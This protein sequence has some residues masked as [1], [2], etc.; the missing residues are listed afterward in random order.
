MRHLIIAFLLAL[1]F[2]PDVRSANIATADP[3][4]SMVSGLLVAPGLAGYPSP[5]HPTDLRCEYLKDPLGIER[6]NPRL[7]WILET[8]DSALRNQRQIAYQIL[9]SHDRKILNAGEGELWNSGRVNSGQSI[10]VRYAGKP[11]GSGDDCFWKVR[12][13]DEQGK[14]SAWSEPKHWHMG[15][16]KASDW[17]AK[18]IGW[19]E[20]ANSLSENS[21]KIERAREGR[22][23]SPQPSPPTLKA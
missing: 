1:A 7:S 3:I 20:Q 14:P 6:S 11:L 8:E 9:V 21:Q 12:L 10:H 19:D 5:L 13:W 15:L 18:W 2:R 22:A 17:H 4:T 16:L 23:S